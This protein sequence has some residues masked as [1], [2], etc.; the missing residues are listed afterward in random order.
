MVACTYCKHDQCA[1]CLHVPV[2]CGDK[3]DGRQCCRKY[4]RN[5]LRVCVCGVLLTWRCVQRVV[6]IVG[7]PSRKPPVIGTILEEE[8]ITVSI[9]RKQAH[10]FFTIRR[11]VDEMNA[12]TLAIA[13][14]GIV[15][16]E[17]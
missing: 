17:K 12:L 8:K 13:L 11:A 16:G 4:K 1:V 5:T 7:Q 10:I 14:R 2:R 3:Q 9:L 15:P 6:N